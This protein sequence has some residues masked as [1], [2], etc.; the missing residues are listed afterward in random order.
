MPVS[1]QCIDLLFTHW[2]SVPLAY[3]YIYIY[4]I[5]HYIRRLAVPADQGNWE[6]RSVLTCKGCV[7]SI[8][9]CMRWRSR[10]HG[11]PLDRQVYIVHTVIPSIQSI[12]ARENAIQIRPRKQRANGCLLVWSCSP[13]LILMRFLR[14]NVFL[15]SKCFGLCCTITYVLVLRLNVYLSS[16][17]VIIVISMVVYCVDIWSWMHIMHLITK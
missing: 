13:A 9:D 12:S 15:T 11:W 6:R 16:M 3:I 4:I 10:L 14:A 17:L 1:R 8:P 7:V 5:C 2:Y